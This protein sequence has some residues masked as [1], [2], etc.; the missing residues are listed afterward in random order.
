M[1]NYLSI[2]PLLLTFCYAQGSTVNKTCVREGSSHKILEGRIG[3]PIAEQRLVSH[4]QLEKV[5]MLWRFKER[6]VPFS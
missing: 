4:V 6:E 1:N 3:T 2:Q 5:Q